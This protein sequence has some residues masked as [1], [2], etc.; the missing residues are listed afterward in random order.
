M[1]VDFLMDCVRTGW[2]YCPQA[3]QSAAAPTFGVPALRPP[4]PGVAQRS[5]Q[6]DG[7]F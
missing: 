1:L 5:Y 7:Q 4:L 2:P 6:L 3:L